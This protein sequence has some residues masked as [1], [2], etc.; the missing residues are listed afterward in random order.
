MH[1][2][3][4]MHLIRRRNMALIPESARKELIKLVLDSRKKCVEY[5][6][7]K[8][9]ECPMCAV[10]GMTGDV[11][12]DKTIGEIRYCECRNCTATFPAIGPVVE[13]I[14]T[15]KNKHRGKRR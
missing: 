15:K 2:I 9:T 8:Q 11:R 12:V 6:D 10:F 1:M 14:V 4:I 3:Q 13:K 7:D 5:R